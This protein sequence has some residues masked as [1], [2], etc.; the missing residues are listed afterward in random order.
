MQPAAC[1]QWCASKSSLLLLHCA[2]RASSRQPWATYE[3]SFVLGFHHT[4]PPVTAQAALDSSNYQIVTNTGELSLLGWNMCVWDSPSSWHLGM[5]LCCS[6]VAQCLGAAVVMHT[7][8]GACVNSQ[9]FPLPS[10]VLLL[11][12]LSI[13]QDQL[14]I[15]AAA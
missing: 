1:R 4:S 5:V 12:V 3:S 9:Q 11:Q 7:F 6:I 8:A 13:Q 14:Q 10:P 15:R 2:R